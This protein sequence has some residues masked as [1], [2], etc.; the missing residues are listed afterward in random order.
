MMMTLTSTGGFAGTPLPV[1]SRTFLENLENFNDQAKRFTE[2]DERLVGVS[3][4]AIPKLFRTKLTEGSQPIR[5]E[6]RS[7]Y[8]FQDRRPNMG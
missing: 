5:P 6:L 2:G 7:K 8:D 3:F 4:E 1:P